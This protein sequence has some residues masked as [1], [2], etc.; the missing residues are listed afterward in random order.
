MVFLLKIILIEELNLLL[1][2]KIYNKYVL[3]AG[4]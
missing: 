2:E 4:D 3:K 1:I